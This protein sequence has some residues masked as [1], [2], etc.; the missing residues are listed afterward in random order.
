MKRLAGLAFGLA[1]L[2]PMLQYQVHLFDSVNAALGG[3]PALSS[4]QLH[5]PVDVSHT[6]DEIT[7]HLHLDHLVD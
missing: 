4:E 6:L 1:L 2:T 5:P 7:T 3:G